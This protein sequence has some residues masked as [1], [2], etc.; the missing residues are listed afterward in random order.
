MSR[1][2]AVDSSRQVLLKE[3]ANWLVRLDT[4]ELSPVE[5]QTLQCW[6]KTSPEH[7]RIWQV[8]C[9]LNRNF[10]H[11][12]G[13]LAKP[14]LGRQRQNRR[15]LLKSLASAGLLLPFGWSVASNHWKPWLA[16][17]RSAIGEL[18]SLTLDDNTELTL[19]T[20]TALDV[21]FEKRQRV[22]RLYEGEV[23]VRTNK[24]K[25]KPV[26]VETAQG[27]IQAGDSE[28]AVRCLR[29]VTLVSAVKSNLLVSP[30]SNN[31][32]QQIKEGQRCRLT[33][34]T[35]D[36]IETAQPDSL[37]WRHGELIA[38]NWRLDTFIH[39]LARYRH[40]IIR[41]DKKIADR[42]IS[43]V[44]QTKNTDQAIEVLEQALNLKVT[45]FTDYWVSIGK[46]TI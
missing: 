39:E 26:L 14:V 4:G 10:S 41:Y 6:H 37:S 19:N 2:D 25:Q 11:L 38:N 23:F 13:N 9:E 7:E 35:T 22:I 29:N 31:H 46:A 12:P 33:P 42:K 16:E 24:N 15:T 5:Q 32:T 20:S 40:G 21:L 45:R 36:S 3:A 30:L 18:R 28:F 1:P 17:Y 27:N 44:F 8:A 43:G 34:N